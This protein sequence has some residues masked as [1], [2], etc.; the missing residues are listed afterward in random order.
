MREFETIK[1]T[2][3][4]RED[5]SR[6]RMHDIEVMATQDQ[7]STSRPWN[8]TRNWNTMRTKRLNKLQLDDFQS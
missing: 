5:T 4:E 2:F 7:E 8:T 6:S 1:V 3:A